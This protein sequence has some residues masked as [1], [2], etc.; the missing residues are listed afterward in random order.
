[1]KKINL[2]ITVVLFITAAAT[3]AKAQCKAKQVVKECKPSICH[4]LSVLR[5]DCSRTG[6]ACDDRNAASR[7]GCASALDSRVLAR[8]NV[9]TRLP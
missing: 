5:L 9:V 3:P 7:G 2:I 1:M 6:M 4:C 8:P